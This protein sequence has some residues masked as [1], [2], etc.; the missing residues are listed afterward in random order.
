[1][2]KTLT[3]AATLAGLVAFQQTA[4]AVDACD[5]QELGEK[6]RDNSRIYLSTTHP[7]GVV[8]GAD[9]R[10]NMIATA[11]GQQAKRSS[12]GTAPGGSV[13][14]DPRMLNCMDRLE[15]VYGYSY[16]VSSIAGASHSAGSYHYSGTAFDVYTINGV[17]VSSGNPYWGT[18]NQRCRDMGSIESLGP[19]YPGHDTHVHNAWGS[20]AGVNVAPSGCI[21]SLQ[22][23]HVFGRG[24]DG[25]C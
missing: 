14:L 20:G 9:P 15:Q 13:W 18:F 25:A 4:R 24:G 6:I 22:N 21:N 19:G 1:M 5:R 16:S 23:V 8:D 10:N 12:Y 17:G 3:L 11:N 7:S 2:K